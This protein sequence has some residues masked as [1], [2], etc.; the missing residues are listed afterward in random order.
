MVEPTISDTA[1]PLTPLKGG[2]SSY[3]ALI[4]VCKVGILLKEGFDLAEDPKLND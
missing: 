3:R 1:Y 2:E 4:V